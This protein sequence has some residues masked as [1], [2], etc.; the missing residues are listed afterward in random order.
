MR[1]A[2]TILLLSILSFNWIG[3]KFFVHYVENNANNQFEAQLDNNNYDED[4]L[5]SIKIPA[6][7]LSE[8]S[9]S[10]FFERVDG[11]IEIKGMVYNFAKRRL[12]N[13]SLELLCIPNK[14]V[15][16]IQQAKNAFFKLVNNI[17]DKGQSKKLGDH[18]TSSKIF[19]AD[20]CERQTDFDLSIFFT[21]THSGLFSSLRI[22]YRC[23]SPIDVPPGKYMN[24]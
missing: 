20:F 11:Q 7:H 2:F 14:E 9:N 18:S 21:N 24:M 6:A 5:I 13:D 3:Y 12:F 16:K 4:Q 22:I 1:K 10:K 8:Y 19:L 17:Q 23:T 15:T